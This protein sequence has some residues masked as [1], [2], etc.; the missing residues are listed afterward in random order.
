MFFLSAVPIM[1]FFLSTINIHW[2][3]LLI[4]SII[5]VKSICCLGALKTVLTA[6]H[7][8]AGH[9]FVPQGSLKHIGQNRRNRREHTR[10][11]G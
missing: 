1:F 5:W 9:G 7:F 3:H 4:G 6:D 11:N 8:I 2:E 10:A